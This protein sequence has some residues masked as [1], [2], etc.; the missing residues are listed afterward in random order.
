MNLLQKIDAEI[1]SSLSQSVPNFRGGD[2]IAVIIPRKIIKKSAKKGQ[3][4]TEYIFNER[5]EGV[6]IGRTSRGMGSNI[7]IRRL[8]M[9]VNLIVPLYGTKIEVLRH[10]VVRRAK[11]YYFNDLSG[12]KARIKERRQ[13]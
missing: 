3:K 4:D 7:N 8:D 11:I 10:G 9:D 2:R 13:Y 6:C 5:I 12:K 1:C